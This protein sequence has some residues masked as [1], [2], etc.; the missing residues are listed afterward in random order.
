MEDENI[1]V[2]IE[3][4][5]NTVTYILRHYAQSYGLPTD[6][7]DEATKLLLRCYNNL[8]KQGKSTGYSLENLAK[9][10]VLLAA[11]RRGIPIPNYRKSYRFL[12]LVG[13]NVPSSPDAYIDWISSE[14]GLSEDAKQRAKEIARKYRKKTRQRGAPRVTASAAI[15]V[16]CLSTEERKTQDE[17]ATVAQCTAV[18]IRNRYQKMS[19]ILGIPCTRW[20]EDVQR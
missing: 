6:I 9:G 17:I 11:R 16:G 20:G 13:G 3:N 7:A 4:L 18:S 1:S 15:Y 8:R 10:A 5:T 19:K 2:K 14:L 12:K